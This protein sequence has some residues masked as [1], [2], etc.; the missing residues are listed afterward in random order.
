[1]RFFTG[2]RTS[3]R[4]ASQ[5]GDEPLISL[6]GAVVEI[7]AHQAEHPVRRVRVGGPD[8]LA[9]HDVV[10]AVAHRLA[11]QPRQIG[12]RRRL[13]VALAPADLA[14]HDLGQVLPLLLLVAELEDDGAEHVDPE[15]VER[16]R[17]S[18]ISTFASASESPPPPYSFGQFGTVQ[19]RSAMRSS[20]S[21]ASGFG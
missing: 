6:I 13:A 1:M 20:Q 7:G 10:V 19:P 17:I 5:N 9:G 18:C 15:R 12:A 21:L 3:W 16:V 8:L 4:N 11:L 2:T 14:A